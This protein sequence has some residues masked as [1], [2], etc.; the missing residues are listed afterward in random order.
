[1]SHA[2][3]KEKLTR[4]LNVVAEEFAS[5][6][7]VLIAVK[8]E[9]DAF[10]IAAQLSGSNYI[11]LAHELVQRALSLIVPGQEREETGVIL[12]LAGD[13]LSRLVADGPRAAVEPANQA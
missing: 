8:V 13:L 7:E 1:M 11:V 2:E 9:P 12:A 3:Y 5:K 4:C 10:A 6:T